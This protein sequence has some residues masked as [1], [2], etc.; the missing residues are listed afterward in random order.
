MYQLKYLPTVLATFMVE[1]YLDIDGYKNLESRC[2]HAENSAET[3]NNIS[4]INIPLTILF[5]ALDFVN[6]SLTFVLSRCL[7]RFIFVNMIVHP[8]LKFWETNACLTEQHQW[9]AFEMHNS[10]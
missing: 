10:N 2:I 3:W 8:P 4:E 6:G 1:L 9:F 5:S 7:L